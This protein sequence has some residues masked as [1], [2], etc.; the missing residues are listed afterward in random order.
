[1]AQVKMSVFFVSTF[2]QKLKLIKWIYCIYF[3]EGCGVTVSGS[4]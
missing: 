1:V 3:L 4:E 2:K